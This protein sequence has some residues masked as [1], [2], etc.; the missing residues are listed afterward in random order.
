MH[1]P[2]VT[3][4]HGPELNSWVTDDVFSWKGA[5]LQEESV[6]VNRE[7]KNNATPLVPNSA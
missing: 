6:I 7:S 1:T 3:A 5:I 4:L 2:V